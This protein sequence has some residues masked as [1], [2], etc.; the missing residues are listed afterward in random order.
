MEDYDGS[1]PNDDL[2]GRHGPLHIEKPPVS[3][4]KK[5]W[6]AAGK[7]I[8]LEVKDPNGFQSESKP[9]LYVGGCLMS[10]FASYCQHKEF[11]FISV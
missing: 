11:I 5:E 4:M 10:P 1:F 6:L 3:P 7:Q 2:H 9:Y 8:G